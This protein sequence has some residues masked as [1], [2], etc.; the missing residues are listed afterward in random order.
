[1]G[2]SV[3]AVYQVVMMV[4]VMVAVHRAEGTDEIVVLS[5]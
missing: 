4:E 5:V 3:E 2:K 1:M